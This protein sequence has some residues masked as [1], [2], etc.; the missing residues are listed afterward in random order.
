[1]DAVV[2]SATSEAWIRVSDEMI[3]NIG[4]NKSKSNK[5]INRSHLFRLVKKNY[6][7][8]NEY[9]LTFEK[10][11]K[12]NKLKLEMTQTCFDDLLRKTHDL[13]NKKQKTEKHY[14]YVLHNPMYSYYGP[15]VYKI[16][17]SANIER[18]VTDYATSYIEESTI[19]YYKEVLS[20][21]C[22]PLVHKVMDVYR[23]KA[24]CEF[25]DCPL[26]EVIMFI[27]NVS[28]TWTN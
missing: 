20:Q 26:E 28:T 6:K 1:M 24:N 3:N 15:N 13:R 8:D 5:S 2:Q 23:I 4:Y 21:E 27:E 18:R 7:K 11:N 12:N 19:V 16:G 25:F 17:Y 22:E 10:V 14:V 9:K